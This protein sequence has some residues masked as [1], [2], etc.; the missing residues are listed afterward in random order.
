M[1]YSK[2][3][4]RCC[5]GIAF[6][7]PLR[8]FPKNFIWG[9]ATSAY[10]IEG[11]YDEDGRGL[12][13]WDVFCRQPGR[14]RENHTGEIA[15]DHFHLYKDDVKL[16]RD[17]GLKAYRFSISWSRILP[18]GEGAINQKGF[19][20]YSRLI[21]ELIENG[22]TPYVTLF[23][24]DLP[25]NLEK[26]YGGWRS[27]EVSKRFADYAGIVSDRLSDRVKNW[28]TI[29]EI[30]CF[31]VL[32]HK[33]DRY[34]PAKVEP[35]KIVNQTIHNALYG[36]G[37]AVRAIRDNAD[38]DVK[39]GIVENLAV[40]Y[41]V[42]DLKKD[43]DAASKCFKDKNQAILFPLFK[44]NYSR[45][46]IKKLGTDM[47]DYTEEEMKVIA[48]PVDFIGY[49]IYGG[50][51]VRHDDVKGYEILPYPKG[52]P[53]T[54]MDWAVSPRSI[55]YALKYTKEY[56]GDIPVYLTEN[57]M[58]SDDDETQSEEIFDL[59]R[60]EYLRTHL[61]MSLKAIQDGFNLKGYFVWSFMDNFEWD[62]GFTK[63]FGIVRVNYST[64]QRQRKLSSYFY[65]NVIKSGSIL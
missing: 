45:Q 30:A 14:I 27:K 29:N 43:I 1:D 62:W 54:D 26:K 63:R 6:V 15:C 38:T 22:I 23:H 33:L 65:E 11:A 18:E 8:T 9:A 32:P 64:M 34:A 12:S 60:L 35:P 4:R 37:L 21:D 3:N 39:I 17:I 36:H 7:K 56:F 59:D 61:D 57:G 50:S 44:G 31:T 28:M 47:P 16:M 13:T 42:L 10:Q 49:N 2:S 52:Y 48:E 20:F 53:K 55:Y 40:T 41:P 51:P 5:K 25:D 58:A 46:M 19:D 24:W